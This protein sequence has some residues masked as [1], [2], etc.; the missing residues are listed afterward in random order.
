M[1]EMSLKAD[2]IDVKYDTGALS[3]IAEEVPECE[4]VL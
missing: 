4:G 2:S 1:T 3:R